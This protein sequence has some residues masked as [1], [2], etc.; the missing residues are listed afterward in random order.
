M[1]LDAAAA[2]PGGSLLHTRGN[3]FGRLPH[4]PMREPHAP[5]IVAGPRGAPGARCAGPNCR[6]RDVAGVARPG[7][8]TCRCTLMPM[9][10]TAKATEPAR[11]ILCCADAVCDSTRMPPALRG[12]RRRSLGQRRST[13]EAGDGA[14]GRGGGE[15]GG[16][17]QQR[18]A[19]GGKLRTKKDAAH[20]PPRRPRRSSRD[21]HGRGRP[22]APRPG[23]PRRAARRGERRPGR[24]SWWNR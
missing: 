16:Q 4:W 24:R 20:P 23:R 3:R 6:S 22:T 2:N 14:D 13:I 15:A 5:E 21:G 9:P 11:A 19:R 12:P 1:H 17:R 7:G 8:R 10:T 18:Q